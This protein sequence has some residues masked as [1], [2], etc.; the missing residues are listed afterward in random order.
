MIEVQI[1]QINT[2]YEVTLTVNKPF[3]DSFVHERW[4]YPT[5]EA[6]L[7]Q[8]KRIAFALESRSVKEIKAFIKG[9]VAI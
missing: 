6:A 2:G 9:G 8:M 5:L 3:V 7:A 4:A 1:D